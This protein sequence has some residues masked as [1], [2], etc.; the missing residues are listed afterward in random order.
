MH[1]PLAS[2]AP[3]MLVL[4]V[5][6]LMAGALRR[7]WDP[8]PWRI[9]GLFG[10]VLVAFLGRALFAGATLLPID[11]LR[12]RAPFLA[13]APAMPHANPLQG[14]LLQLV[15][16]SLT[17]VQT[18]YA[19]GE[20]PLWNDRV[21]AGMPLL[22]DPQAQALQPLAVL[23]LLLPMTAAAGAL[24][25]LRML[26]AFV[27]TFLL[28]RRMQCGEIAAV[29]GALAW[30]CGGFVQLWLGW[31]LANVAVL[32][33][34]VLYGV[35]MLDERG[36]RRDEF[37]L[38]MALATFLLAGHPEAILYGS[39]LTL[40]FALSRWAARSRPRRLELT[41]RL[42]R[43]VIVAALLAAPAL[44][45]AAQ[46]L[47]RSARAQALR[48]SSLRHSER[49]A[50][51]LPGHDASAAVSFSPIALRLVPLAAPNA[52]GNGR[53]A[54]PS[55]IEYWGWSN[56][57]EDASGFVGSGMLLLAL[58]ALRPWGAVRRRAEERLFAAALLI[59]VAVLALPPSWPARLPLVG[60]GQRVLLIAGLS[61]AVLGACELDRRL[62]GGPAARDLLVGAVLLGGFVVWATL[63]HAHPQHPEAMAVVRL[64]SM[65]LEL[66]VLAAS[67]LF[68]AFVR[69][70]KVARVGVAAALV[71]ELLMLH[72]P[73]NPAAELA[74][75]RTPAVVYLSSRLGTSRMVALGR[76]FPANQPA[77]FGLADARL[78]NP[79][80]PAAE[81]ALLAPL[82]VVPRGNVPEVLRPDDPLL[83]RLAVRY[84]LTERGAPMPAAL[85]RAFE[86]DT[87]TVYERASAKS[88]V[89]IEPP[90][91]STWNGVRVA[92]EHWRVITQLAGARAVAAGIFQDGNWLTLADRTAVE[93]APGPWVG[94]SVPAKAERVD[95]IYRPLAALFG[96]LLAGLGIGWLLAML[97][98]PRYTG[99]P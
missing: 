83:D 99:D 67:V 47:P 45:P 33:P 9:C 63:A 59:S 92:P 75:P 36:T 1:E 85:R 64:G 28:L 24:A 42:T 62:Q 90:Q 29:T 18:A 39:V 8:V 38:V 50:V 68:L 44:L 71:W 57:N 30:G 77:L 80:Q 25:A 74:L 66:K 61:C 89:S 32:L 98:R 78:Y 12:G 37:L 15:A 54:D 82:L 17:A 51:E 19:A 3:G 86:D 53:Y 14:D 93:T 40:G 88:L 94:A 97:G 95:L 31:P 11:G 7:W 76:A 91:D 84:V 58:L 52:F 55:G 79:S 23:G 96:F 2:V 70:Y 65:K 73:A 46:L 81:D 72:G 49:A 41:L 21:G 43:S 35:A 34:Y 56:T 20:W 16:P 48:S 13:V 10:L 87:S 5:F 6:V 69:R 22:A 60:Q 26:T 27:F 4:V